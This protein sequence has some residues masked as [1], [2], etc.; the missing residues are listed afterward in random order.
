LCK[1]YSYQPGKHIVTGLLWRRDAGASSLDLEGS[2]AKQ[3]G[4]LSRESGTDQAIG[5]GT[6]SFNL[7]RWLFP[8]IMVDEVASQLRQHEGNISCSLQARVLS[9]EKPS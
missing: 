5:K 1:D 6:Q 4:P 7:W 8:Q 9:V 3:L 2:E